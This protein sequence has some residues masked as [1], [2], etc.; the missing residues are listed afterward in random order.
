MTAT[1]LLALTSLAGVTGTPAARAAGPDDPPVKVWLNPSYGLRRGER[2][3]VDVRAEADGYLLVLHA[4][5]TGRARVLFPL[6]PY[7]D[8]FVRGGDKFQ[9]RGR[10]DRHAFTIHESSGTGTVLAAWSPDPFRVQEFVRGDHWDYTL[11]STWDAGDDAEVYLLGLAQSMLGSSTLEYDVV[12][13]D[14]GTWASYAGPSR[15]YHLGMYHG[16]YDDWGFHVSIGWGWP[17]YYGYYRRYYYLY[18][19]YY[20]YYDPWY[21]DPWYHDPWYDP[22]FYRPSWYWATCLGWCSPRYYYGYYRYPRAVVINNY[23]GY[24]SGRWG[25]GAYTFKLNPQ[26]RFAPIEPRQRGA[27]ASAVSRRLVA[28]PVGVATGRRTEVA[29]PARRLPGG[30][31]VTPAIGGTDRRVLGREAVERA[32]SRD[33][34]TIERR[35][36]DRTEPGRL[37]PR[38]RAIDRTDQ[39]RSAQERSDPRRV[40]GHDR[41]VTPQRTERTE[42][43]RT[44]LRDRAVAPDREVTREEARREEIRREEP[45][46]VTPRERDDAPDQPSVREL[47]QDVPRRAVERPPVDPGRVESQRAIERAPLDRARVERERAT[48]RERAPAREVRPRLEPRREAP[49]RAAPERRVSPS[50]EPRPS[51]RSAPPRSSGPSVRSAP[52][53]PRSSP[54]VRPSGRSGDAGRR[55]G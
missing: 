10:G 31:Q 45:R 52:A 24:R 22:W 2:V 38:E 19:P 5:P 15:H 6:D 7:D 27:L 11:A 42:P 25:S 36:P 47:R 46:R 30:R 17:H 26:P 33:R 16:Y 21:Y 49:P 54:S 12:Q 1:I 23:Y 3:R 4:D 44:D 40:T 50:R 29:G 14:V 28:E 8:H 51:V 43:R 18:R 35:E 13:Y 53:A 9:L 20:A 37:V 34:G 55:R 48:V 41:A 32:E 39:E